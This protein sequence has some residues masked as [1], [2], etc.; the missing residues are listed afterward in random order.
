MRMMAAIGWVIAV[1]AL[2]P[3]WAAEP[4]PSRA[5]MSNELAAAEKT[6]ASSPN[7]VSALF[8]SA[9]QN[10]RLGNL[11]P[12]R[13]RA[14]QLVTASGNAFAAWELL[15]QVAQNQGDKDRRDRAVQM[16]PTIMRTSLDMSLRRKPDFT[17]DRI[18]TR[19]FELL[20]SH[21]FESRDGDYTRYLF[22]PNIPGTLIHRGL[23]LRTDTQTT[24]TWAQTSLVPSDAPL[25]HLDMIDPGEGGADKVAIYEYFVGEP[26]YDTVRAK[27]IKI[28]RGEAQ[29]LSGQPG[30]LSGI[31]AR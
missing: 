19:D 13:A 27:V 25:F 1:A 22:Y 30:S 23:A 8:T 29:P 20:V 18:Q 3:A 21:F 5:S 14:E 9:L 31:M 26:D 17:R 12:A 2:A 24:E 10:L 28:L 7:D 11:G 6:L 4:V 15:A 16:L